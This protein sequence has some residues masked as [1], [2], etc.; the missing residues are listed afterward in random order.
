MSVFSFYTGSVFRLFRF[1]K[2]KYVR[3]KNKKYNLKFKDLSYMFTFKLLYLTF[4]TTNV[5]I[6]LT[7]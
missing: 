5:H 6:N 1:L 2:Q 7:F 3:F 4:L